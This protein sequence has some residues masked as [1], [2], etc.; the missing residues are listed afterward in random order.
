MTEKYAGLTLGVDVSQVNNAVKSLRE[1][2]KANDEASKS[3]ENFSDTQ[4]KVGKSAREL[5]REA[6]KQREEFSKIERIIDPTA[7]KMRKLAQAS[8][9]LDRLWAAGAV[10]DEKFFKLGELLEAQN[11][12]LLASKKALTEEGRAAAEN[13]AQKQKAANAAQSFLRS[14]E[15]EVA[16]VGKTKTEMLEL[17]AAQLGISQQAAPLIAQLKGQTQQM[18]LAGIS[19]GQY[20]Q[21]MRMLPAQITD[22]V[23]SLASGMPVWMVAIQQ[24]GQIKDS[25]GGVGNT[26]KVMLSYITPLRV[27]LG[28]TVGILG[29]MA[30]AA[31]D[32][33]SSNRQLAEALLLTGSYAGNTTGQFRKLADEI[34][35]GSN[36]TVGAVTAIITSLAKSGR[37]TSTQ[38]KEITRVTAQWAAVTGDSADAI[39]K[40]FDVIADDPVKGLAKLNEQF[41][42]LEKGQLTYISKLEDTKGKTEAVTEATKLFADTMEKRLGQL[43]ESA[44]PLEK[45][46]DDIKKWS[47]SAWKEIGDGFYGGLNLIIDVVAGTIEQIQFLI[48]KGDI[49][50]GNFTTSVIKKLNEFAGTGFAE[51]FIKEQ[52]QVVAAAEETNKK[53]AKSIAERDK[54]IREGERGYVDRRDNAQI[55]D[56]GEYS[57]KKKEAIK[58]EAD[59]LAKKNKEQKVSVSQGERILDQYNADIVALQSQ[60][61]VLKEHRT[62]NDSIS[63][64]RKTLWNEQARIKILEEASTKRSLTD[65]EKSVLANKDKILALKEQAA[66]IGDQIVA[67]ERI[68][69]LQDDSFK[70]ITRMNAAISAQEQ[71]SGLGK[72]AAKRQQEL[73]EL[74][75]SYISKGGSEGDPQLEAMIEKQ[76]EFYASEDELR[77]DWLAGAKAAFADFG[78][79]AGDMY[80]NLYDIAGSAMG[81]LTD[82]M[83]DFLTTGQA[84]FKDFAKNIIGMIIKMITQMVIFNTLAGFM[85]GGASVGA[86]GGA[87][88]PSVAS[89]GARS[90][91][92]PASEG[93]GVP[94]MASAARATST[95]PETMRGIA[96][97]VSGRS[98]SAN[99]K[100]SGS[101]GGLTLSFGNISVDVNNGNDPK[102]LETGVKMIVTDMLHRS[103][104]QGGEI[105]NFLKNQ[106]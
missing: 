67:Q 31:Y 15:M 70:F 82:M 65:E 45:M 44:N 69:K 89:A 12:K 55:S 47:S 50:V 7:D 100:S 66:T 95:L 5:A 51:G 76:K 62:I 56:D 61:A 87:A 78:E 58:A 83:V 30:K 48:N 14:L 94:M 35:A 18:K 42:F 73:E 72:I 8:K 53:L 80:G 104:A 52:E 24:G 79:S 11:N 21:A 29:G 71:S 93:V 99:E 92:A 103:C 91:A 39:I 33:Y 98:Q 17:R 102:G 105:Y 88:A 27:A 63:Q 59:A 84:S 64:Q 77:S 26:F 85:G 101:G 60:L 10:P 20:S 23:T 22:V 97:T 96:N 81:G 4:R 41:N 68:N 46:W 1:M 32:S 28:A 19:A 9:E 37:Y 13:A 3:T 40:H 2:K 43:A 36:A 49:M 38:I 16:A 57:S 6:T 75:A 54:R 34:S 74:K 90:F 106:Q 25:F 86:K